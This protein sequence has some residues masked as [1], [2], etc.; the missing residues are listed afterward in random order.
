MQYVQTCTGLALLSMMNKMAYNRVE[1]S[2]FSFGH[3]A[4]FSFFSVVYV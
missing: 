2:F 4:S 1:I 3:A